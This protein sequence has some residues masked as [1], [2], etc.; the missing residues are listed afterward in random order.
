MSE[1]KNQHINLSHLPSDT[2]VSFAQVGTCRRC[3]REEDLRLGACF[4][5]A[6][7]CGGRPIPGG[8][9]IWDKDNPSNRW[10]VQTQ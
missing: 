2:Y 10:K 9:E 8:H 1:R 3:G 7:H 6:D 4:D 5:C